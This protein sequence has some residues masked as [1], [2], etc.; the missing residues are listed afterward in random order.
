MLNGFPAD[1]R[2]ATHL[3]PEIITAAIYSTVNPA[4]CTQ[5]ELGMPK[6]IHV[7]AIHHI[8][9][10]FIS[11]FSIR[12]KQREQA[13]SPGPLDKF[14]QCQLAILPWEQRVQETGLTRRCCL[15]PR[16]KS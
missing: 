6:V 13:A 12:V 11:T 9:S 8:L 10:H 5:R 14:R 16:A 7:S 15:I 1:G 4:P 3:S 2:A